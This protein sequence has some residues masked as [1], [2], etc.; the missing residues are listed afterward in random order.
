MSTKQYRVRLVRPIFQAAIVE[1]EAS[2]E[3]QAML[4]ALGQ[5]ESISEKDWQG[6]FDPGSY[7]YDAQF[8]EDAEDSTD[9]YIFSGIDED[10]KY[11]LLKADTDSGE[12]ELL[13]QPWITEISD[14]MVADLS[15]DW[16]GQLEALEEAGT[17]SFYES[18]E[19]IHAKPKTP[20]KIIPFRRP[21][22]SDK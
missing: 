4:E 17:V 19:Q 12:G 13:L 5:A 7:F 9:D 18:L 3:E 15:M 6:A 22:K 11:L 14:L 8:V 21:D 2:D 1:V 10:R 20:A 16:G